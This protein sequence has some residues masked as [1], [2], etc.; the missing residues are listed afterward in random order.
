MMKKFNKK[1]L[2]TLLSFPMIGLLMIVSTAWQP[3]DENRYFKI[4]KNFDILHSLFRELDTY[5]VDSVDIDDV[6]K[7]AVDGM[8]SSYDPYTEYIPSDELGDLKFMTTGEYGGIGAVIASRNGHIYINEPY[9]NMPAHKAGLLFGDEILEIDGNKLEGKETSYASDLL[10]GQPGTEVGLL[11]SR[12]GVKK[13]FK[14]N[15]VRELIQIDQVQYYG[16][17]APKIGYIF[18]SSFTDKSAAEVG[19]ALKNLKEQGAEK[20]ILDL[21]NNGGGLLTEAVSICNYFVGKGETIVSTRSRNNK[22]NEVYKTSKPALDSEMP[23]VIITNS[24]SASASEIVSGAMQDLDRAVILGGRTFGKG[25]VQRT[26]EL[27]YD[28]IVKVTTAKYYI[29]S[30]RCI[31]AIDYS[32]RNEDGSVGRIPDSLTTVFHTR[33][34]R[35]VRDGGGIRPDVLITDSTFSNLSYKLATGTYFFDYANAYFRKHPKIA[36]IESF[37]LS[38]EEYNDFCQYVVSTGVEYD[39]LSKQKINELKSALKLEG[40]YKD[41]Q[42]E[43]NNLERKLDKNLEYDLQYFRKE[44]EPMLAQEIVLRYY[45]QKGEIQQSLKDDEYTKKAIEILSDMDLYH[46]YLKPSISENQRNSE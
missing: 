20:M 19:R 44:I 43:L 21:R 1:H 37:T 11:I 4:S 5:Y 6:F 9:E 12:E 35:E 24:L 46:S 41:V 15:I 23:L 7:D 34:G 29:P 42:E 10:R 3:A 32:N 22:L 13:P 40:Y 26:L 18:L 17:I 28:G 38:D 2:I 25:L 36:P 8:L 30:G 27:P 16:M 45:Y 14:K 31:Q 33:I 39:K